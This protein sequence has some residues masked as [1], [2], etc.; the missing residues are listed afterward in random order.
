MEFLIGF[1]R[2]SATSREIEYE[3][4]AIISERNFEIERKE[5]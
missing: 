2:E 1:T 5:A 3:M 4:Y